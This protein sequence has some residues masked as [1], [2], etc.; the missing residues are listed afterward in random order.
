MTRGSRGDIA[1][2]T[3]NGNNGRLHRRAGLGTAAQASGSRNCCAGVWVLELLRR[4][5]GLGATLPLLPG[6]E[7]TGGCAGERVLESLREH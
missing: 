4:R 6:T 1:A 5:A 7:T 3:G 2:V